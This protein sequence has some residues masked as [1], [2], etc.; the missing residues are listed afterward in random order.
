MVDRRGRPVMKLSSQ[1]LSRRL[2]NRW[3]RMLARAL[4]RRPCDI[5]PGV[6]V[7]SFS[8]DDFPTSALAVAG[9]ILDRHGARGTYYA[10]LGLAGRQTDTGRIFA[11]DDIAALLA[12]GHELGCHTFPHCHAWETAPAEFER[13]LA[14]N[15][16]ALAELVPGAAFPTLSYPLS[17]PRP[18]NKRV[19]QG[20]FAC[21]RGGGQHPNVGRC[22]ANYLASYFLEQDP[23]LPD[24]ANAMI[25]RNRAAGGWLIFSTHDVCESPTR[26]G[27]L[28]DRFEEVVRHAVDSGSRILPVAAAWAFVNRS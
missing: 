16:E 10:S 26:Y 15:R 13:A 27:C 1:A 3:R 6:P 28:P 19:A 20:F 7:I 8:F 2:R 14:M 17:C 25:D 18:A 21:C 12:R 9:A 11:R 22:D 4:C 5:R 23:G 24:G